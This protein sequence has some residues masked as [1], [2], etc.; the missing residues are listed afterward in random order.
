MMAAPMRFKLKGKHM[1]KS[2]FIGTLLTLAL[3][4]CK[5]IST[6]EI[7]P[8][9]IQGIGPAICANPKV[10]HCIK[11]SIR[12]GAIITP[13][14]SDEL[15]I[16]IGDGTHWVVWYTDSPDYK[17]VNA[18]GNR[19]ISFGSDTSGQFYH[20]D[21]NWCHNFNHPRVFACRDL[22]SRTGRF[23]YVIKVTSSST[24]ITLDPFV[25]NE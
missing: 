10:E 13:A 2:L 24:T 14:K 5:T 4:G 9:D 18:A 3:M 20:D 8:S 17:F 25:V 1:S 15:K 23:Q 21:E 11:V 19:P 22:N 16:K 6:K 12:D 7:G